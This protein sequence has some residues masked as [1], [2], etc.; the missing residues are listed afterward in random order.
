LLKI[1]QL[2]EKLAIFDLGNVLFRIDFS[3]ALAFL[4]RRSGDS[5][6]TLRER[7]SIGPWFEA[8][9]RGELSEAR[10]FGR[11]AKQLGV[12]LDT[13]VLIRGWNAIYGPVIR[14]TYEAIRQLS[15]VL[16]VVALTNTNATHHPVWQRVYAKELTLFN[17]VFVS[18]ELGM[19]K[20]E[21]RIYAHVLDAWGVA[22]EEA[23]FFDDLQENIE[24][25]ADMGIATA[26]VDSDAVV[27][28][29]V[30]TYLSGKTGG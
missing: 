18:S 7:V 22:P 25:A 6:H 3:K 23:V 14:P 30:R 17:Q 16:P 2:R 20:P 24:A 10:F 11:L 5:P 21:K 12:T 26:L 15:A 9:E 28:S 8:F 27:A 4:A 29:W 13:E 1:R 19:R